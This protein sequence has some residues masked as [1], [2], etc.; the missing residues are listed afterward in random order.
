MK[1][2]CVEGKDRVGDGSRPSGRQFHTV[3]SKK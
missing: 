2:G 3:K 1:G